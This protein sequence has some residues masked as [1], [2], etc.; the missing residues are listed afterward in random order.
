MIL[1]ERSMSPIGKCYF[2]IKCVLCV[3]YNILEN[4]VIH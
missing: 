4:F 3:A 1:V 2:I